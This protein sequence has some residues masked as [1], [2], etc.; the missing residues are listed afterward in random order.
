M[1]G[2]RPCPSP[3]RGVLS[4]WAASVALVLA[5]AG[6]RA[7]VIRFSVDPARSGFELRGSV[8]KHGLNLLLNPQAETSLRTAAAGTLAAEVGT[9]AVR[10]LG[11]DVLTLADSGV[12]EPGWFG[13]AGSAPACW[14]GRAGATLGGLQIAGTAAGRD[15]R[16]TMSSPEL[17]V[18]NAEFGVRPVRW[19]FAPTGGPV[20]D[21]RFL[22][23]IRIV[24]PDDVDPPATTRPPILAADP[25]P[26]LSAGRFQLEGAWT[27]RTSLRAR[28]E[29]V[30]GFLTLTLPVEAWTS[31]T[32]QTPVGETLRFDWILTGRLVAMAVP[33]PT[34]RAA[35]AGL[36]IEAPPACRLQRATRLAPPDWTEFAVP[37]DGL[38]PRLE[39][40]EFF[41]AVLATSPP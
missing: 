5:G 14:G 2:R 11:D 36:R 20:V 10:F 21:Y 13:V 38:V 15:W 16:L 31:F 7:E 3:A 18:T 27:N 22:T 12:W 1:N 6:T 30:D 26:I 23:T 33:P 37:A 17:T 19:H 4:R 25:E 32:G 35:P 41:R 29:P 8:V 34:I 40:A 9:N 24:D 28:L 39:T